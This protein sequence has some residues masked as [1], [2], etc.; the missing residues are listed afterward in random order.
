LNPRVVTHD[1]LRVI[2][3]RDKVRHAGAFDLR[4]VFNDGFCVR[5]HAP[6]AAER[7]VP[8]RIAH[9]MLRMADDAAREI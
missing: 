6:D 1:V 5:N 2:Q 7:V 3:K 4:P 8:L 9:R